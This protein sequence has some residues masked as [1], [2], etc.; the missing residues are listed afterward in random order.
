[1]STRAVHVKTTGSMARAKVKR[2]MKKN[3]I[4][5]A[6]LSLK[7]VIVMKEPQISAV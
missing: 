5:E 3:A 2:G 4:A 6:V 7:A 1:M